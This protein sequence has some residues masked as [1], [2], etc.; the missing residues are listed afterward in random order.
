MNLVIQSPTSV[1]PATIVG[2]SDLLQHRRQ[3]VHRSRQDHPVLAHADVDPR[4]RRPAPP[5]APAPPPARPAADRPSGEAAAA[6]LRRRDD[7]LVAGA[8]AEV[9][10]QRR[11]DLALRGVGLAHPEPVERHHDPRRAEAALAAVEIHHRLLH[12][13]QFAAA[14]QVLHRHHVAEIDR[15]QQPDAGV[16][17]L[18]DQPAPRPAPHQHRAGAAV[19][20]GAALLG[21]AQPPRQPQMVEQRVG[22]AHLRKALLPVVQQKADLVSGVVQ[23]LLLLGTPFGA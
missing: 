4:A 7:R 22:R 21:A 18:I 19:A 10:L 14:R 6:A 15:G 20:L 17:R 9:A 13:M 8:A 12:R 5:A 16:H 23:G 1:D 2:F 11:L 3:V